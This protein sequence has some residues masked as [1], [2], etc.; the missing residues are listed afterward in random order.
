MSSADDSICAAWK[1]LDKEHV[2]VDE[3]VLDTTA[4]NWAQEKPVTPDWRL[5]GILP[6]DDKV[7]VN[8]IFWQCAVDFAFT[9]FEPPH[10]K[11]E[12]EGITGSMA[13][14]RC[15]YRRFGERPVKV[16][17]IMEITD[18]I[19]ETQRF[20]QGEN[21]PPLLYERKEHLRNAAEMLKRYFNGEPERILLDA[22]YE[23]DSLVEILVTL[24]PIA[25]GKDWKFRKR[26]NL[27]ALTYQG[28]ALNSSGILKPLERF[29]EIGPVID[30][31]IPTSLRHIRVM[32]YSKDLAERI[33]RRELIHKDSAEH[34]EIRIGAFYV[35]CEL[36][37]RINKNLWQYRTTRRWAHVELDHKLYWVLGRIATTPHHLT[38]TT[39]Y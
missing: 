27:F 28:R 38:V 39:D 22:Y 20:F 32:K 24:F 12:V 36:L 2:N 29:G 26:A 15:F 4:Y 5:K 35:N 21:L 23:A 30:Y 3:A 31:K 8:R 34:N 25:F 33:D 19:E 14:S 16:D 9:H 6:D 18:S 10:R 11:Y 37:A 13:M 17:E 1:V 7:F